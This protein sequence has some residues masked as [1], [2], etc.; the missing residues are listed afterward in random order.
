MRVPVTIRAATPGSVTIEGGVDL[1]VNATLDGLRIVHPRGNPVRVLQ[2]SDAVLAHCDVQGGRD[3]HAAV[4]V[5]GGARVR[6]RDSKLHDTPSNALWLTQGARAEVENTEMW[7]CTQPAVCATD[8]GTTVVLRHCRI[9]EVG[10]AGVELTQGARAAVEHCHFAAW[11][12]ACGAVQARLGSAATVRA[13]VFERGPGPG[14]GVLDGSELEADE[15]RFADLG[16]RALDVWG[17]GSRATV[18]DARIERAACGGP[19]VSEGARLTA[20]R[21]DISGS[22]E[23]WAGVWSHGAELT[24]RDCRIHDSA[25]NGLWLQDGTRA[26]VKGCEFTALKL[27]AIEAAGAGVVVSAIDCAIGPTL[28]NGL[29]FHDDARLT[30]ERCRVHEGPEGFPLLAVARRAQ[31]TLRE[32]RLHDGPSSAAWITEGGRAEFERCE[33]THCRLALIV[34]ENAGTHV[35]AHECTFRGHPEGVAIART[36]AVAVL[37]RCA[38]PEAETLDA[39]QHAESEGEVMTSGC[40][41]KDGSDGARDAELPVAG[42]AATAE[43]AKLDA[44]AAAQA[45]PMVELD[46]LIGLDGVKTELRKLVNLVGVQ[47]RRREQGLPVAPVSL[48]MVFTG[49]PGTGK[50]TVARLVGRIYAQLGLLKSGHVVEVDRS[51]LVAGY[52]GQTAERVQ[53]YVTRA[54]GGVL[55][56]DE[57]YALLQPA[58]G[59]FGQ[60]AIDTLLKL[61]EDRRGEFAVIAAGYSEPMLH[62]VQSN[63][64][65]QSRFTRFIEFQDYDADALYAIWQRSLAQNQLRPSEEAD[66]RARRE[67]EEMHRVRDRKFGNARAVR[68][69]FEQ[70]LERQAERLAAQPDADTSVVL[71]SDVPEQRPALR[72]SPEDLLAELDALIGLASVKAE[73]RKLVNL[74]RAN[75]RRAAEGM[76]VSPV[77]LHLVFTGNPGT[78]KTTVARLVGEIYAGLG[79]LKRGH[80]IESDRSALVGGWMGQTAI[81]TRERVDQAIDGVLFVDEAYALTQREDDSFGREAVDTLL[82]AMEDDRARLAVIAAGYSGPMQQFL[83]SNPGLASRF[84][85]V[86]AFEDYTPEEM[87]SI[88]EKFCRDGGFVLEPAAREPLLATLGRMHAQRDATFG[89]GRAVRSLFEATLEQQAARLAED[90]EAKVNELRAEDVGSR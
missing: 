23:G 74:A 76:P 78:G 29:W 79:L 62:F 37:R 67:I 34:A 33:L 35:S 1:H 87:A 10:R 80:V 27:A 72:G 44:R 43:R 36:G 70:L 48:H 20:E 22:G 82:K 11:G 28:G 31:A 64:G 25:G 68:T 12:D 56:V 39:I 77:S 53:E 45:D 57:A 71:E 60:E 52:I 73:V 69:M 16:Y 4:L 59:D 54:I 40:T 66:A 75:Q 63:P 55:F 6:I 47:V 83:A 18:R 13:C 2:G 65:L 24:V 14:L 42:A 89:N 19:A 81:K 41:L 5:A 3:G 90:P 46:S 58:Q 26:E 61:M 21:C 84:S 30:A 85:R 32:C 17:A 49:N 50:T 15:C 86:I 38:M 9:H 7:G 51:R 8:A 88:F